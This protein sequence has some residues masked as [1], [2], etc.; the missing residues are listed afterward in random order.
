MDGIG[1]RRITRTIAVACCDEPC[2]P[3]TKRLCAGAIRAACTVGGAQ[4]WALSQSAVRYVLEFIAQNPA[5]VSAYR[6]TF[7]PDE[8][9]FQSII[10]NAGD[11]IRTVNDAVNFLEWDRPGLVLT[12]DDFT[13]LVQTYYLYARKF[14][15]RVDAAVLDMID[16]ELL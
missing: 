14:D 1:S 5:F 12:S 16:R 15:T 4:F 10:G 11:S 6:F 9:F 7:V 3:S 8:L 13:T 2:A